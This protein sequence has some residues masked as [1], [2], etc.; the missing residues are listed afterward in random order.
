[1]TASQGTR[2]TVRWAVVGVR[3]GTRN[4]GRRTVAAVR[5]DQPAT[6][7]D[8][9]PAER[10]TATASTSF[11]AP[12]MSAAEAEPDPAQR[13]RRRKIAVAVAASLV[14]A[15]WIAWTVVIWDRNGAAAGIGV[16]VSW[17]A[18]LAVLAL[19]TLP[20]AAAM[21]DRGQETAE[22]GPDEEPSD[23]SAPET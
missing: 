16:L 21:S 2:R 7:E 20:F 13:R 22:D 9:E 23:S 12:S 8:R 1:M 11:P 3:D 5:G 4:A 17:P 10:S 15:A 18:V 19:L 14:V 6:D